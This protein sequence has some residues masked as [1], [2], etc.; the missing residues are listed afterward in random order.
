VR[1][2]PFAWLR[3]RDNPQVLDFLRA[4][5]AHLDAVLAHTKP[6]Q[7]RLFQEIKGR[8]QQTDTTVPYRHG[9]FLYYT[10][11]EDGKEY[12]IHCRKPSD[13]APEQVLL[14]LN[15]LARGHDHY[16]VNAREPSPRHDI[17][18]FAEDT[19]GDRVHTIRF[20]RLDTG[21]MLADRLPRASGYLAW[22]N[23]NRTLFYAA[24]HPRTLRSY[25]VYRHVLGTDPARDALIY[26]ENDQEFSVAVSLT[27][28]E[29]YLVI[30]SYQ[31]VTTECRVIPA[32]QPE[33]APRLVLA[34]RRGHEYEVEHFGDHF[35]L[36]TN[37][38]ARNF[39]LMRAPVTDTARDRWEEVVPHRPE[40]LLE[41]IEV[42]RDY[43]VVE[44]RHRGLTR[45]RIRPW[46]GE[47]EHDLTFDEP[48]YVAHLGPNYELDTATVRLA[49]ASLTTPTSV[50][51][52]DMRARRSTLLKREEVL[53]DFAPERYR[54]ERLFARS[55]DGVEVPVSLVYR[56]D[57]KRSGG[58]PLLLYG[59][60]AYGISA[61]PYFTS[62]RLS[63]LDR[64]FVY[65]IAHVRGGEDLGRPW[66]EDGRLLK[67][68]N[69]FSDYI[70]CAEHLIRQGYAHPRL[71]F[72]LGGSAGGLL[73]GAVVNQRP[74]LFCGVIA[75][76]PFVD[77]VNTMLDESL[78]LTTG[79]YDEWG[80]PRKPEYHDYILSYS[81]YD[82]V[83]RQAYPHLLVTG[84]L[85]DS[86]VQYWEP[87]KWVARLRAQRTNDRRLLL[88][89]NMVA[90]HQGASGRY[91]AYRE[92]AL[93]YAF[94]LDLAG[95]P[96]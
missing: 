34:R 72:G 47:D 61:D 50:Y 69:T 86:Q 91:R 65:A 18:A 13:Q 7:E 82:N 29:A 44:E 16:A 74:D 49:Y 20:K 53:G 35:Y 84:G 94:L 41:G 17:L 11:T 93:D 87:A 64:G 46:S 21:A 36:R 52:Y 78:P 22:A 95:N 89:I 55:P 38:G 48:A 57:L 90:G 5:N 96:S 80:D 4:E 27:K 26:E 54:T 12:P 83:T 40:V 19:R 59:Y 68:K 77:V 42:F 81:P 14:D 43:L 3:G 73:M 67:K 1:D 23:D 32:K 60:G 8:I 2:D 45:L 70:A 79:E 15:E 39:R 58:N 25:R 62:A 30:T 6:L 66:Y 56:K 37:D 88:K 71:L 31:T 28:T 85:Y 51:D 75:H 9:P 92:I 24:V 10:R 76:V 33:T 63:L